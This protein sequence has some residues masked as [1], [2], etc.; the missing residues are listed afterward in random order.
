[1]LLFYEFFLQWASLFPFN[2]IFSSTINF[3]LT[4]QSFRLSP[5]KVHLVVALAGNP[6]RHSFPLLSYSLPFVILS[7]LRKTDTRDVHKMLLQGRWF[8]L[9]MRLSNCAEAPLNK[10][11]KV[12]RQRNFT[13]RVTG[14]EKSG[15]VWKCPRTRPLEKKTISSFFFD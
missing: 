7:F 1:M 11:V 4:G 14:R 8:G 12:E 9:Q 15:L 13:H 2:S 10:V 5:S 3:R 6:T